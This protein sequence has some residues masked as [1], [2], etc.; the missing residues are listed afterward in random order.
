[1][2][3]KPIEDTYLAD[4]SIDK[5]YLDYTTELGK[6]VEQVK[7]EN[8]ED[9]SHI[10]FSDLNMD[11]ETGLVNADVLK[12]AYNRHSFSQAIS[13]IRPDETIGM[14]GYLL[15]CPPPLRAEN[16]NF[17][18]EE[19]FGNKKDKSQNKIVLR[20]KTS[21]D[22][23]PFFRAMVSRAY[24]PVDD[25]DILSEVGKLIA[26]GAHLQCNRGDI[27]SRYNIFWPSEKITL[28]S[29]D[30]I[31][32]GLKVVNSEVLASS[33][34]LE[35][36]IHFYDGGL[37]MAFNVHKKEVSVRHVGEAKARLSY[38]YERINNAIKP[39]LNRL[40]AAY[41]SD[42]W[43]LSFKNLEE[44]T[45]AITKYY[46]LTTYNNTFTA[47][48]RGDTLLHVAKALMM[49]CYRHGL[50][51]EDGEKIQHAAGH[52]IWN[53]WNHIIKLAEANRNE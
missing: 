28:N 20:V 43:N 4:F 38:A 1:M 12:L 25:V 27:L 32:V 16:F 15:A 31:S 34:D 11:P 53:G 7:T 42:D 14:A 22:G 44:M 2:I 30:V 47:A 41:V 35:P 5:P 45:D 52:L 33:V 23:I 9:F 40:H 51:L 3:I 21:N 24:V 49:V 26:P 8:C 36:A 10:E 50:S 48:I 39:T 6:L 29:G 18:T 46:G 13:R 37:T 17:W 19:T